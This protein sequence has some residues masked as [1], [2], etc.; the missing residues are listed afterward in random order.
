MLRE[1]G[2]TN[3]LLNKAKSANVTRWHELLSGIS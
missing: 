2:A 1:L 3:G